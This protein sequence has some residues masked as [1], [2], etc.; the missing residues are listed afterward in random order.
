MAFSEGVELQHQALLA[1]RARVEAKIEAEL[2]QQIEEYRR[3]FALQL[4]QGERPL[5]ILSEGDSW[6]Q[7]RPAGRDVIDFLGQKLGVRVNNLAKPGD[8]AREILNGKQRARLIRE[9]TRGPSAG[10]KY[11]FLLFSGGGNDLV[12]NDRFGDWLNDYK[13]GMS[14][15]DV[16]AESK[17]ELAFGWLAVAYDAVVEV[18]DMYSPRTT[19]VFH[20]YDFAIPNGKG[21]CFQGPW[22][23]PALIARGVPEEMRDDV[24]REFLLRF[25]SFL[26]TYASRNVRVAPTQNVLASTD[27][28]NE[29]HP[30]PKGFEKI[31]EVFATLLRGPPPPANP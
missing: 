27:W 2:E 17:L 28:A 11:D 6:F 14:A 3:S 7:Y 29:L 30:T 24:V 18:R 8:E 25:R 9:L 12:G 1:E 5:A 20:A 19:A 26:E 10:R 31:A 23:K 4:Q 22:L 16:I 21:V 13:D 15:S